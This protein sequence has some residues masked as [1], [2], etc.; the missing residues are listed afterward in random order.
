MIT[1][2]VFDFSQVL[3]FAKD[4]SIKAELSAS[5]DQLK[6][7]PGFSFFNTFELNVE[8]VHYLKLHVKTTD[9]YV[10]S[11]STLLKLPEITAFLT[12]VFN[13]VISTREMRV[14]KKDPVAYTLLASRL[15]KNPHEMVFIDD[16]IG[17][18]KAAKIAGLAG[19]VFESNKQ[20]FE[21]WQSLNR[22]IN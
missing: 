10:F 12:E 16:T 13:E 9:L 1:T 8:L 18:V 19:I 21:A 2:A 11:N 6:A 22:E 20:F 15:S 4:R 17:N 7:Q 3:L 5:Y 14:D